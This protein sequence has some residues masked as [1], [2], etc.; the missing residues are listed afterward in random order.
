MLAGEA[1]TPSVVTC[2]QVFPKDVASSGSCQWAMGFGGRHLS[3]PVGGVAYGIP[4]NSY[5][6]LFTSPRTGPSAVWMTGPPCWLA[7]LSRAVAGFDAT[8]IANTALSKRLTPKIVLFC[9]TIPVSFVDR[10]L[11][12]FF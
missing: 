7:S 5:T 9:R 3:S 10:F 6:P 4:L 8:P 2:G 11:P 1:N 12:Q